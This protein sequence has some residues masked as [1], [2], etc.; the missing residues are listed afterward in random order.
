MGVKAVQEIVSARLHYGAGKAMVITSSK[1]SRDAV[2][3]AESTFV[4][5]WDREK[6]N[7]ELK[8][9]RFL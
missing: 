8:K 6:L 5:L 9:T 7:N 1:F 3:L 4:D 2:K